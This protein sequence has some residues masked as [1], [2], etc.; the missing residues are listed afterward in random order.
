MIA[1]RWLTGAALVA[2]LSGMPVAAGAATTRG[3]GQPASTVSEWAYRRLSKAQELLAKSPR[4]A[5][6]VMEEMSRRQ[7]LNDH[8]RAL[9]WQTFGYIYSTLER[10]KEAAAAFEN[11]LSFGALPEGAALD[12][13]YNL[14]QLY[15]TMG[16]T[17]RAVDVFKAWLG[18]VENPSPAATYVVAMA[19]ARNKDPRT[20]LAFAEDAVKRTEKPAEG[21]LQLVLSLQFELK[22]YKRVAETLRTLIN[23]FPRKTYFMQLSAVYAE[24]KDEPR[25]LAVMELAHAQGFLTQPTELSNLAQ[26]RLQQGLPHQ[27]A[28][29]VA[30]AVGEGRLPRDLK[31]LQLWAIAAMQARDFDAAL[32]PLAEAAALAETGEPFVQLGQLQL[33]REDYRAAAAAFQAG[34]DKGGLADPGN[35]YVLL[36]IAHYSAKKMVAARQAFEKAI[37]FE[38]SRKNAEQWLRTVEQ[39]GQ[40]R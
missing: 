29:L 5:L 36:G 38:R 22:Q 26:F 39:Q 10:Y 1:A 33:G 15:L 13:Q 20:A 3:G 11:C 27:A 23:R 32:G 28:A 7:R 16:E 6:A 14:G 17:Q 12:T 18:K 9:M 4:E 24:L 34:I 35:A 19:Y 31:T 21:W 37:T 25:S 40:G 30:K 8:E 2:L